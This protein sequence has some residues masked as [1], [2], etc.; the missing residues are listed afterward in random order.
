MT[1]SSFTP[2]TSLQLERLHR[3]RHRPCLREGER[4]RG[5]LRPLRQHATLQG[6]LLTG[7]SGYD[8]VYPS[9]EYAG[10]QIQAGIFQ[11]LDKSHLPNLVHIDPLILEAV[12]VA[13][14]GNRRA[15]HVVLTGVAISVE[16]GHEGARRQAARE[17]LG[18][19]LRSRAHRAPEGLRHRADG[20]GQRRDPGGCSTPASTR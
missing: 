4:D 9:V 20:R 3:R 12:A 18:P 19:A 16:Q 8:V 7:G 5:A 6:K 17:R 10:K 2:S 14:P 1:A 13:D 15:L 11:P